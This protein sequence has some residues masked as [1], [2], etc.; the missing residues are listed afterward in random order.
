ML[1]S[2][3]GRAPASWPQ[4]RLRQ[5]AGEHD[6]HATPAPS[7]SPIDRCH[8]SYHVRHRRSQLL[9]SVQY[10][11]VRVLSPRRLAAQSAATP[12]RR[13]E[14]RM[15]S[16]T[17]SREST[18]LRAADRGCH[19]DTGG[20]SARTRP[21]TV[22]ARAAIEREL[23]GQEPEQ[24]PAARSL[25]HHDPLEAGLVVGREGGD[26]LLDRRV[27]RPEHRHAQ[28]LVSPR[29]ST[30]LP[31]TLVADGADQQD[32]QPPSISTP[33]PGTVA[34]PS[35]GRQR[36]REAVD[37]TEDPDQRRDADDQRHGDEEPG[38]ETPAQP[39]MHLLISQPSRTRRA[40]AAER[41]AVPGETARSRPRTIAQERT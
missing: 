2:P 22:P 38:D 28:Q 5:R 14:I 16:S 35:T 7:A 9:E 32:E 20:W 6:G 27:D 36:R 21:P 11:R 23:R 13:Q 29:C 30:R 3:P 17:D 19:R 41:D 31:M 33:R 39:R 25:D 34:G 40:A 4:R 24:Q 26:Q 12:C 37:E 10:R 18:P 1:T 8:R 15:P